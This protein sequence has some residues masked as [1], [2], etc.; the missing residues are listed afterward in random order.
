MSKFHGEYISY[1]VSKA[2]ES[3]GDA[4]ILAENKSWNACV[5]R[6]YYAC[7]YIVSALLLKSQLNTQT[8]SGVKTLFNLHFIK[9]GKLTVEDGRLNSDLMDWRQKGDYGDMFDFDKET[10]LP[11]IPLV[12]SFIQRVEKLLET[13]NPVI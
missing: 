12:S 10:F 13:D 5:N 9:T 8:H 7:Y 6:L 4:R 1:R 3:L 2:T 11:L